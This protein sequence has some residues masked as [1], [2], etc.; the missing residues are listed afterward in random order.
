MQIAPDAVLPEQGLRGLFLV[1][2]P[3]P[4]DAVGRADGR[5]GCDQ[6]LDPGDPTMGIPPMMRAIRYRDYAEAPEGTLE[7]CCAPVRHLCGLPLCPA[8][9]LEGGVT[10]RSAP[11]AVD[12]AGVPECVPFRVPAFCC[13]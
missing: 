5:A 1:H 4:E 13:G 10:I 3:A 6:A 12:A 9:P 8:A 7:L 11:T 2:D